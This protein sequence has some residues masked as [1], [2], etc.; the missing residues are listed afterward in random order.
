VAVG[1]VD[2]RIH[3]RGICLLCG[4]QR[5]L[6]LCH[7]G[8]DWPDRSPGR[9]NKPHD[10][11]VATSVRHSCSA[12]DSFSVIARLLQLSRSIL[13]RRR[14]VPVEPEVFVILAPIVGRSW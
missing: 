6:K 3:F 10:V 13:G 12:T 11:A 5:I 9:L 1:C 2:E 4:S 14:D 8:P 7:H